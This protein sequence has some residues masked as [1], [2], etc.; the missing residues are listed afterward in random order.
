MC[1]LQEPLV[2]RRSRLVAYYSCCTR[3]WTKSMWSMDIVHT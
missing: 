3:A 2:N 1:L